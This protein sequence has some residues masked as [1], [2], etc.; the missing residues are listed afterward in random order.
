M[1]KNL[2]TVAPE[3]VEP[4][5]PKAIFVNFDE[6]VLPKREIQFG[7]KTY[8]IKDLSTEETVIIDKIVTERSK[9][10]TDDEAFS[11]M[12][13]IIKTYIPDF[14]IEGARKVPLAK[15]GMLQKYLL[16]N[17]ILTPEEQLKRMGATQGNE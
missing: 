14:D 6:V 3:A 9:P 10:T 4:Q 7:G 11:K 1:N 15:L 2:T 5:G 8:T 13:T 17:G 16:S 12:T